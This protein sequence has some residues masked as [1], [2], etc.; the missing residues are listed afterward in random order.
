MTTVAVDSVPATS[1]ITAGV[2]VTVVNVG[3]T[4]IAAVTSRTDAR[5]PAVSCTAVTGK[6]VDV[7]MAGSTVLTWTRAT[8]I[9]F[10]F[11]PGSAPSISTVT[12]EAVDL[13]RATT[14]IV[15]RI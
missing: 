7:V 1:A 15:A 3:V 10:A 14:A 13:V 5:D 8:L 2:R 12:R 4:H 11:T 6:A 9:N